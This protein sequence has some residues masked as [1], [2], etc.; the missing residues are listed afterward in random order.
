MRKYRY[1][2]KAT[3]E[4]ALQI[5][6]TKVSNMHCA[7]YDL[8]NKTMKS[9]GTKG[10]FSLL[11]SF[12]RNNP[13][14]ILSQVTSDCPEKQRDFQVFTLEERYQ[15]HKSYPCVPGQEMQDERELIYKAYN[16]YRSELQVSN[17]APR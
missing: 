7:L 4:K 12:W 15:F 6:E 14:C 11:V 2:D 16:Q 13:L 17:V 9:V 8:G 3:Y 10:N 1:S 5:E